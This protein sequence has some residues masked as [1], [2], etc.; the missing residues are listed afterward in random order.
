MLGN[1][2]LHL[3]LPMWFCLDLAV[4]RDSH[5][6]QGSSNLVHRCSDGRKWYQG[7]VVSQYYKAGC[8]TFQGIQI[9]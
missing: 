6:Q 7:E 2:E 9:L 4:P 5:Y 1:L 3:S 8:S